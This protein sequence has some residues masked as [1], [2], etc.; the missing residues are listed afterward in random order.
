MQSD[1]PIGCRGTLDAN[2]TR[3]LLSW[4]L[5]VSELCPGSD[6]AHPLCGFGVYGTTIHTFLHNYNSW[7]NTK[8]DL[9]YNNEDSYI[10]GSYLYVYEYHGGNIMT[11]VDQDNHTS[12][13][14]RA[15]FNPAEFPQHSIWNG[16]VL[17]EI[18]VCCSALFS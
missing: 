4:E 3:C 10:N 16:F 15:R 2:K 18:R 9:H 14:Y 11:S 1:S 17:P 5:A 12:R 8:H 7:Q 13:S 6:V